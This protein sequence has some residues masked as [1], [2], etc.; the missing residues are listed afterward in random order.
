VLAFDGATSTDVV[1]E[2]LPM[3]TGVPELITITMGGNDLM[4]VYG[5]TSAAYAAVDRV[6]SATEEVLTR[7]G[8]RAGRRIVVTTVYDPSDG[9]GYVPGAALPPWP[10]GSTAVRARD[11]VARPTR[12]R[13]ATAATIRRPLLGLAGLALGTLPLWQHRWMVAPVAGFVGLLVV[14]AWAWG[15]SR[16][17]VGLTV[18]VALVAAMAGVFAVSQWPRGLAAPVYDW[19]GCWILIGPPTPSRLAATTRPLLLQ[20]LSRCRRN[21]AVDTA[22]FVALGRRRTRTHTTT[23]P[24]RSRH[25]L[26]R[27]LM[28]VHDGRAAFDGL[29]N[30]IT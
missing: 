21:S 17:S 25:D 16:R 19:L 10:E 14:G 12:R 28:T 1:R 29:S 18:G 15:S 13:L 9:T 24:P 5:N 11:M 3:I 4:S 8:R 23:G 20:R 2:Q 6:A 7:L 22:L 27:Q 30:M 26:H